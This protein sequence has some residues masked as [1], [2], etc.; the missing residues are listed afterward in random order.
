MKRGRRDVGAPFFGRCAARVLAHGQ[1]QGKNGQV[2][3]IELGKV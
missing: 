1:E 2:F 3:L